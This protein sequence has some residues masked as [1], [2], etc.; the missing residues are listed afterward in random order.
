MGIKPNKST[1]IS[2]VN[3]TS[4]RVYPNP[5]T[6]KVFVETES[7]IKVF[8]SIGQ[9]LQEVFGTEVSLKNYTSGIY[10]IQVNGI[11][12]KIVKQ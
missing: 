2:E 11:T 10:F 8:S 7:N 9:L 12:T 1:G 4:V 6:D 5:T 3:T